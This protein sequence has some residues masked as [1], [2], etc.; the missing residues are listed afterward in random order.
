MCNH[1]VLTFVSIVFSYV[2]V[3]CKVT[4]VKSSYNSTEAVLMQDNCTNFL[5]P[6]FTFSF[7]FVINITFIRLHDKY[8]NDLLGEFT[9][10][11]ARKNCRNGRYADDASACRRIVS[12]TAFALHR[13]RVRTLRHF[14]KAVLANETE[15]LLNRV[16]EKF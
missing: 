11:A 5:F 12:P 16:Y 3:I 1:V 13:L 14:L 6:Q 4:K 15:K 8:N 9:A 7:N 2:F 10:A